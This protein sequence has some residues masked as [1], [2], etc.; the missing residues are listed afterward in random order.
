MRIN[1][2]F[3][4]LSVGA[5]V[6]TALTVAANPAQA[7]SFS[8]EV[9]INFD[10][11]VGVSLD[12]KDNPLK[13]GNSSINELWKDYGLTMDSTVKALWLYDSNCEADS[14]T[15]GDEDL[16]TGKGKNKHG[17]YKSPE[18]GKVLIVQENDSNEADDYGKG[19]NTIKFDFT[20]K[21]GVLFDSIGLLDFDE[22]KQPT[23]FAKF[24]DGTDTSNM[25]NVK[26]S[27][28]FKYNKNW[29][30]EIDA[31]NNDG[32]NKRDKKLDNYFGI[33]DGKEN[34]TYISE[35]KL[36]S[37]NWNGKR[38]VKNDNSL[39]EYKFD[40]GDKRVTE[41]S[42]TLPGS[43]AITG[44]NYYRET[45]KK[46]ARKVPEPTSILGL[47]AI[48]GLAASSLKKKRKSSDI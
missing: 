17:K 27:E 38:Y 25:S 1:K 13:A 39:R 15:G 47:V 6:A 5:L 45:P 28:G 30:Q 11:N 42:I 35:M 21:A 41:F 33:K 48:S 4:R 12:A 16:G 2:L 3:S 23:F 24:A 37:T 26:D 29:F 44:L 46:L 36:L 32:D 40:F 18:Q 31:D 14:C 8:K 22:A 34:E 43:G 10:E 19:K 20:D 7:A 9:N